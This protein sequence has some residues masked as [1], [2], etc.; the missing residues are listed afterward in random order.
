[1]AE[2]KRR[3][4]ISEVFPW[5]EYAVGA[6]MVAGGAGAS[7]LSLAGGGGLPEVIFTGGLGIGA[8][9]LLG[10]GLAALRW[11]V[12]VPV[13][14]QPAPAAAPKDLWD[15]WLDAEPLQGDDP[16]VVVS[17][18]PPRTE[19][20]PARAPV[21]PRIVSKES[22][23]S[24]PLEDEIV[25]LAG[26]HRAGA[27]KLSGLYGAGKTTA[28]R[29]LAAVLPPELGVTVLFEPS[30]TLLPYRAAQGLV[31]YAA[32]ANGSSDSTHLANYRLAP[33]GQDEWIEYL[34]AAARDQCASV[35]TQL[36][37][38]DDCGSLAGNPELWRIVLDRMAADPTLTGV[39]QALRQ[40]LAA[41]LP[42][43][44]DLRD[45]RAICLRRL[46]NYVLLPRPPWPAE[47][48]TVRDSDRLKRLV[49]HRPVQVLLAA[50]QIA[51]DLVAGAPC[52][53]LGGRLPRDLVEE[54]GLLLGPSAVARGRLESV[55][56]SQERELHPMAASLMHA[57]RT[58]WVPDP[59]HCP[60]L[61]EAFLDRAN[62]AGL[63]LCR[64]ELTG[65][66]LRGADLSGA[67]LDAA[68][69]DRARLSQARLRGAF[70]DGACF[71]SA[72][73]SHADL[74]SARGE[75]VEFSIA[76]LNGANLAGA[77]LKR[78][79]LQRARLI[80]ARLAGAD[81]TRAV[82]DQA[83]LEQADFT[84]AILDHAVLKGLKLSQANFQDA[85]FLGADL[86]ACDLEGMTL[87]EPVFRDA[88][89]RRALLTG[90]KLPGADFRGT[91]LQE[92]GL[93]EVEWEGACLAGADLRNATFHLGSSRSGLVGSPIASEGSRTGFYTDD[94][95]EQDFKSPEEIRKANL[96]R[97][98]LRGARI[99][100]VDFYLVDLRGARFDF[101][102]AEHFRRCGAILADRCC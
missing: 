24:L 69:A 53:F 77:I 57:S 41:W 2:R 73:L 101:A 55:L 62:W 11:A 67:K 1:M 94:F 17:E 36:K 61:S 78:A 39:R 92:A 45:V 10:A 46:T 49:R 37:A 28:L 75:Q 31:V 64:V 72:D 63:D 93:A 35:M 90:S 99:D 5:M 16:V 27:I 70:L 9:A 95:D 25:A 4:A 22:G 54:A 12:P 26:V 43:G 38:A 14:V 51:G 32:N 18:A 48:A 91:N 7:L 52:Q 74:T 3:R 56:A 6:G 13:P 58:G 71:A 29:H 87:R 85:R 34:L 86:G 96:C 79:R 33:W 68:H 8:G 30:P 42:D 97:A 83:E 59:E 15:P 50:E 21:R 76:N 40:E 19:L 60:R 81:L 88:N 23:E 47:P 20:G 98:D 65:T 84:G 82:L 89:L 80:G 102:Q 66:S 100:G 44:D